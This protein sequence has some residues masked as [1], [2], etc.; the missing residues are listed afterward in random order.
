MHGRQCS[1][2]LRRCW[3]LL[4]TDLCKLQPD[5]S[6]SDEASPELNRIR[7]A[8]GRQHQAIEASLKRAL[9]RL[10]D[11]GAVQ[12]ALITVRGDR[13]VIPVKAEAKRRV[14]GRAWVKL[15][16]TDRLCRADGNHRKQ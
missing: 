14:P 13:F 6:L 1:S 2:F 10:S 15:N 3:G 16:R 9:Q 7:R 4:R 11:E 12:D 5:G 8:L